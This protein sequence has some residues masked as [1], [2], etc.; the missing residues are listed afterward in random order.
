[1]LCQLVSVEHKYAWAGEFQQTLTLSPR[2]ATTGYTLSL[3]P[4]LVDNSFILAARAIF[5]AV[6]KAD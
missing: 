5:K 6:Y 4:R 1:M 3:D 2:L